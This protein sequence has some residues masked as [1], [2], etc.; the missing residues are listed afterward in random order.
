LAI[1][2]L[3]EEAELAKSFLYQN[4]LQMKQRKFFFVASGEAPVM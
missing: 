2:L 1:K 4:C 3:S